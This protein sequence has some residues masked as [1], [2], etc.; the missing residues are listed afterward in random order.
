MNEQELAAAQDRIDM[1][2]DALEF[3]TEDQAY[4]CHMTMLALFASTAPDEIWNKS[5]LT[6]LE[7][8]DAND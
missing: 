5:V 7:L 2:Y 1:F 8:T 6:A 4:W 3:K